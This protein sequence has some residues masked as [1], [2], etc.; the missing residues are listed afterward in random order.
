MNHKANNTITMILVSS[1][2]IAGCSQHK[3][4]DQSHEMKTE[5]A[6]AKS[7]T[8][9][10]KPFMHVDAAVKAQLNGFLTDYF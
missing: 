4:D 5:N 10:L 3:H 8:L 2:L 7:D 1:M 6:D 9:A